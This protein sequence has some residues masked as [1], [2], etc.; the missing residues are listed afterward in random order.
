MTT[1]QD[2]LDDPIKFARDNM[3]AGIAITE[4]LADYPTRIN[5]LA[6][7]QLCTGILT[8]VMDKSFTPEQLAEVNIV[9]EQLLKI[10]E[11]LFAQVEAGFAPKFLSA[12]EVTMHGAVDLCYS[13]WFHAAALEAFKEGMDILNHVDDEDFDFEAAFDKLGDRYSQLLDKADDLV[14]EFE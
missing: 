8:P 7:S 14:R 5:W 9:R 2:L 1:Y 3:D 6:Y 13:D 12:D 10:Q 4:A 11:R